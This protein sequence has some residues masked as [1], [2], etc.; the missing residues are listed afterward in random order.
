MSLGDVR[1]SFFY[2]HTITSFNYY[3]DFNEGGSELSTTL[4]I[5]DYTLTEYG[6]ELQRAL[7]SKGSLTYTVGLDRSTREFSISSTGAFT[8]LI[9]SGS[10]SGTSSYPLAG[11][12][13]ADLSGLSSYTANE[14][15]GKEYRPQFYLQR[16]IDKDDYVQAVNS[17][18]NKAGNGD[19]EAFSFGN[20]KFMEC[21]IMYANDYDNGMNSVIETNL[22]G[23]ANLRAFLTDLIGKTRIEFIHDRD[24]P[25]IFDSFILESSKGNKSGTGFMLKELYSKGMVGY[26]E[27]GT[28][29]FRE[30]T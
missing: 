29:K 7:N 13:G 30:V 10:H 15:S 28:L 18:I 6:N 2:G 24:N 3:I 1:S 25:E 4:N 14:K 27:T 23:V 21:N 20:E 26:Y 11:F 16:Y 8:L 9:S 17:K 22:T 19:V 12:T 5:G